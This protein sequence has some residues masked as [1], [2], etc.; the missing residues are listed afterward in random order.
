MLGMNND[1]QQ[2][3]EQSMAIAYYGI[4][5]LVLLVLLI[6]AC[7][8]VYNYKLKNHFANNQENNNPQP[9]Q[10]NGNKNVSGGTN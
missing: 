7:W 3:H 6:I 4:A 5:V 9:Q 1:G 8:A 2:T 10:S